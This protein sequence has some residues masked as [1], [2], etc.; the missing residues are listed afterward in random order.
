[1][2]AAPFQDR[3]EHSHRTTNHGLDSTFSFLLFLSKIVSEQLWA[4]QLSKENFIGN[5]QARLL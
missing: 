1:V 2:L 5:C 3:P 4:D